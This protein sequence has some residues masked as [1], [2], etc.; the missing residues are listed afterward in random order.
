MCVHQ[1]RCDE[2]IATFLAGKPE[3]EAKK[4]NDETRTKRHREER[5]ELF[6]VLTDA[7]QHTPW[8]INIK[9]LRAMAE[10]LQAAKPVTPETPPE[11]QTPKPA[12]PPVTAPATDRKSVV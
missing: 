3:R 9:E 5:S 1:Y 10:A 7:G 2:E 4:A 8:N 6:K 12:T 11:T